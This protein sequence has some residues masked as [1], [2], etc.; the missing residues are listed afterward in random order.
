VA[1]IKNL[2]DLADL[3]KKAGDIELYRRTER[4]AGLQGC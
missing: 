3:I 2:K 1:L 4:P